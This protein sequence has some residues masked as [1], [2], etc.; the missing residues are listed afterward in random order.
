MHWMEM[1]RN[2]RGLRANTHPKSSQVQPT[3]ILGSRAQQARARTLH[4]PPVDPPRLC[5]LGSHR[6][7]SALPWLACPLRSSRPSRS[8]SQLARSR[9]VLPPS[10]PPRINPPHL[11]PRLPFSRHFILSLLLDAFPS[12]RWHTQP[13]PRQPR[14]SP[15]R[16]RLHID[17]LKH[18]GGYCG[19]DIKDTGRVIWTTTRARLD[20]RVSGIGT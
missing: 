17:R 6:I 16:E 14:F 10:L 13:R 7:R 5:S 11:P 12:H 20:L 1:H 19:C 4:P 18:A 8:A 15:R 3:G 9:A 2:A